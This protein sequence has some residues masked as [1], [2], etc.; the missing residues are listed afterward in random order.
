[1]IH[2]F[3][4]ASAARY[5][6]K[7]A[8]IHGRG[9]HTYAAVN[10]LANRLAHRL[11]DRGVNPGDRIALLSENGLE[12][13]FGFYGI[14]KAGCVAVPLNTE[15]K[16]DGLVR[17]LQILEVKALLVSRKFERVARSIDLPSLAAV[18]IVLT[19]SGI[20]PSPQARSMGGLRAS[21]TT[22]ARGAGARGLLAED[23]RR[24]L[25]LHGARGLPY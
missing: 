24:G 23:G 17:T 16:P 22:V 11:L 4:E 2:H 18:Q 15:I 8:I 21:T 13:V 1:M 7:P 10:R 5:P 3:L 14:L 12:Y 25:L 6:D 19:P 9:R 20:S